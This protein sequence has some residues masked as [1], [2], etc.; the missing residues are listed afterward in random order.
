[1]FSISAMWYLNRLIAGAL[2]LGLA[3]F[4]ALP[5]AVGLAVVSAVAAAAMLLVFRATSDQPAIARTKRRIQASILEIRLFNEQPRLV[6]AAQADVLRQ[7]LQY[8]RLTLVPLLWLALP[9]LLLMTH[10]QAY[11]GYRQLAVG[12]STI[13]SATLAD[14]G[15][16]AE[17]LHLETDGGARVET[18]LLVIPAERE[19]D[20]RI[21]AVRPGDHQLQ[22]HIGDQVVTKML[23]VGGPPRSL[24]SR[25]PGR[26]IL[27]QILFPSEP[28][29]ARSSKVV[30]I[31]VRYPPAEVS[32][33]GW[34]MHWLI[35]FF[36]LTLV[37]AL[38]L[39]RPLRV[40]F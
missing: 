23:Q 8:F 1:V 12:E 27:D 22:F 4:R 18:P 3:P 31:G 16:L 40:T 5:P 19:V 7:S 20:W 37:A 11:Y 9:L 25:R 10:L 33:L 13:L 24:S 36:I 29:L 38:A 6:L 34:D 2:E 17:R 28:P 21:A 15:A 35:A 14:A 26:G 39:R 30:A 32:L